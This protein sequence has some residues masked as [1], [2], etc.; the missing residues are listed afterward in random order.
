MISSLCLNLKSKRVRESSL[1]SCYGRQIDGKPKYFLLALSPVYIV[2]GVPW[3]SV[4]HAIVAP[5]LLVLVP[6]VKFHHHA[7][8]LQEQKSC[9]DQAAFA[10]NLF[11]MD[12]LINNAHFLSLA[13]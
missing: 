13:L 8:S 6:V 4:R 11:I 12:E 10:R 1:N 7:V 9:I 2:Y 5:Y 3:N